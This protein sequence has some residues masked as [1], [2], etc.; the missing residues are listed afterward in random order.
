MP[1]MQKG[2]VNVQCIVCGSVAVTKNKQKLDMCQKHKEIELNDLKC[3]CGDYL[4]A[5]HGKYG[6]FFRCMQCGPINL[7]KAMDIND[8]PLKTINEL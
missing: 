7:K 3:A 8:L 1:R 5:M 4:D 2:T 6:P